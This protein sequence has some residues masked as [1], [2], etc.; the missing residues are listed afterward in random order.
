MYTAETLNV[1][2]SV[3]FVGAWQ[4]DFT[5]HRMR[6]SGRIGPY[7]GLSRAKVRVGV[8]LD[9]LDP[10]YLPEDLDAL[11]SNRRRLAKAGGRHHL[12]YGLLNPNTGRSVA[13]HSFM[14]VSVD[15]SG[16]LREARG[17]LIEATDSVTRL[18]SSGTPRED[19]LRSLT[20]AAGMM[21]GLGYG[22]LEAILQVVFKEVA[23]DAVLD[24]ME[25]ARRGT[26]N[27]DDVF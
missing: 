12:R 2:N 27:E 11:K 18:P 16:A 23:R 13:M 25:K 6:G 5:M 22:H 10:A 7:F 26:L 21:A 19:A 20:E 14:D 3:G 24:V 9:L 8:D 4:I 1:L 17:V 15:R